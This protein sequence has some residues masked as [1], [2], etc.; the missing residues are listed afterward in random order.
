MD[1]EVKILNVKVEYLKSV[2]LRLQDTILELQEKLAV[3]QSN[4]EQEYVP[5]SAVYDPAVN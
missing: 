3:R 4:E 2:V 5:A 1:A